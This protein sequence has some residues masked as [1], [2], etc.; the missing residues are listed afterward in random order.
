MRFR[1]RLA[2]FFWGRNGIDGL[3]YGMLV[4]YLILWV[5][6]IIFSDSTVLSFI[7][8]LLGTASVFIIIF[9]LLSRNITARRREN[10]IFMGFWR[11]IKNWFVLQKNKW[12]DRKY[13]IYR[14]CPHCRATLRLPKRSGEH[15]V[16]CP[17]CSGR[18]DVKVR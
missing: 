17:K 6:Q 15:T 13:F 12:R 2:R 11:K 14:S 9:R 4:L 3:Y 10:E 18:F 5:L 7:F 8:G 16:K 1:D